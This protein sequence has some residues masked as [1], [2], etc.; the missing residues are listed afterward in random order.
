MRW[1]H[2]APIGL[3]GM[4]AASLL[5]G[6]APPAAGP[7]P[8]RE[9]AAETGLR[10]QHF[11]GSIG[12]H[13]IPEIMGP[14]AALF[15]YDGDG[16]LDVFLVQGAMLD[17]ARPPSAARF[18]PAAGQGEGCR[19]FRND[20][21]PDGA[22]RPVLRFTD[23]TEKAGLGRVLYGMGAAVGDYDN[24]GRPDLYVTAFGPNVLFHNNGDGTFTD[25][26]QAAGVR[27]DR[28][29]TSATFLDY[30]RDGKL[31]LFV[32]NY[33]DFTPAG[34]KKCFDAVGARDYCRPLVYRSVTD[35]LWHNDGSGRFKD[36]TEAAGIL[37]ADGPGLGVVAADFD[38]DGWLDLYV[39]NDGAANQLWINR[40]DGTFDDQG[41]LSGTAYNADGLPEGSM[42]VA[43]G[44]VDADGDDDL[45]VT[46]LPRE[47]ATLYV[48]QGHAS[49]QDATDAWGLGAPTAPFT[50]FGTGFFDYDNDG[51]LDLFVADGAVSNVEALR[52][53]SYPFGERN[54][55][56][57]NA[58]G[59]RFEEVA[60]W[61][62]P[63]LTEVG[64]GAAFGDIDNDGDVDVLVTNNNGP[65]RLF[66]N[67]TQP[68]RPWLTVRLQGGPEENAQGLG[69]RI[70]LVRRGR[71][72][73]WR[74]AHTDGSYLSASD[75]RVHFGL[76]DPAPVDTVIVQWPRG[77]RE[78]WLRPRLDGFLTLREG[79]GSP[80]EVG[81]DKD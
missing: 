34:N 29:S 80:Y 38:G 19:L 10:F 47:A 53:Q 6:A 48:N 9:V 61:A 68:T 57:H 69:A 8:F 22:G 15:D 50:G 21:A 17:P 39:A 41:L 46:N 75:P 3:A 74:R 76:G 78:A 33:I 16:D 2:A 79:E 32:A 28:W 5:A 18:P 23:V 36:V 45:F 51:W 25:V 55:L 70:G 62:G 35:R 73:L 44:D 4:T 13:Y 7:P 40:A 52:G 66:L 14:G 30:D 11:T 65:V 43:A 64:R 37:K 71:P 12:E 56:L 27:D 26:T 72:T 60:G 67:Q 24:D 59:R 49:F 77:R 31:D 1:V 81:N 20:L 54:L 42:G 63:G 58:G